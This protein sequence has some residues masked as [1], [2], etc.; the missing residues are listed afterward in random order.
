[1]S[2]LGWAD[3]TS[4]LNNLGHVK[5]YPLNSKKRDVLHPHNFVAAVYVNDLP[6]GRSGHVT[7]QEKAC[8]AEF[9]RFEIALHRCVC[10][11]VLQHLGEACDSASSESIDGAGTDGVDSNLPRAEGI[12]E[13]P[14]TG[15]E[16]GLC[17]SHHI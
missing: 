17:D 10:F 15:F 5:S 12:S 9:Q 13:I 6:G 7:G 4:Q 2:R 8:R 3:V 11:I 1:M 16:R 14:D